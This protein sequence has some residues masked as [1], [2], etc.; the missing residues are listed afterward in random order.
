[1]PVDVYDIL[2]FYDEII[3][4]ILKPVEECRLQALRT[5]DGFSLTSKSLRSRTLP[6]R[7]LQLIIAAIKFINSHPELI[8]RDKLCNFVAGW[9]SQSRVS[10]LRAARASDV[11]LHRSENAHETNKTSALI[12]R[13]SPIWN[14]WHPA[15][16]RGAVYRERGMN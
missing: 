13:I 12:F 15:G 16:R 4:H 10:I 5:C 14:L 3:Y 7:W 1:M 11:V 9:L 2:F 8:S 6:N